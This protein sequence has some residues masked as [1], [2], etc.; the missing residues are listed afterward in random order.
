[1]ERTP[2]RIVALGTAVLVSSI[3]FI[4]VCGLVFAC[5]CRSLWA[6]AATACNIH[7]GS[8][9]H[10][11]WCA[12]PL[13]AG[14]VAFLAMVAVQA[15]IVLGPGRSGATLRFALALL[16]FPATAG[17]VGAVQG[18]LWDYWSR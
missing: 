17:L 8:G 11:P 13:A 15:G 14:A 4:D 6:G 7:H 10:C 3:F 1:M 5:G 12:H 9:P 2:T 16:S 18:F